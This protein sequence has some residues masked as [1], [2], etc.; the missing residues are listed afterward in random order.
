MS[1]SWMYTLSIIV[2]IL[3]VIGALN[4]GWFGLT[5]TNVISSLNRATFNSVGLERFIY[6]L[7]GLA[8]IYLLFA[9]GKIFSK[10]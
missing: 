8:G 1:D 6:V 10:K 5:G 3:V 4:W 2:I 7:V 9:F